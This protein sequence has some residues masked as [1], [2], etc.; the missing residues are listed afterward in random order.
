MNQFLEDFDDNELRDFFLG[1]TEEVPRVC[2][3]CKKEIHA[4][5]EKSFVTLGSPNQGE[6]SFH[7]A[8]FDALGRELK[9]KS[10]SLGRSRT[11]PAK[12]K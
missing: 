6:V 9:K 1:N 4:E 10:A 12:R 8:C 3:W 2:C 11:K 5:L 7:G